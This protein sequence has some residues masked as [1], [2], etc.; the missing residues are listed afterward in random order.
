ME[1]ILL[2]LLNDKNSQVRIAAI[3][4]LSNF[5]ADRVIEPLLGKLE[6]PDPR[7][8]YE[9]CKQLRSFNHPQVVQGLLKCLQD[10]SGMVQLAAIETLCHLKAVEAIA[11][12]HHMSLVEDPYLAEEI[13]RALKILSAT[14]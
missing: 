5:P 3:K 1:K 4:A 10:P 12:L 2:P 13:A 6:D 11:P 8:R 9:V 14:L 7:V